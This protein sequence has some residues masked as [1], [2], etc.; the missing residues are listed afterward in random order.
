VWCRVA[1]S[2]VAMSLG[3][4]LRIRKSAPCRLFEN[5]WSLLPATRH[6]YALS[7]HHNWHVAT[8]LSRPK[9]RN[10]F[11]RTNA[12]SQG[13]RKSGM[14]SSGG[15]RSWK[16]EVAVADVKSSE[17]GRD[18]AWVE[19][20]KAQWRNRFLSV[21]TSNSSCDDRGH[22]ALQTPTDSPA[23]GNELKALDQD[24]PQA[25]VTPP[26]PSV[27][28]D[29]AAAAAAAAGKNICSG[30]IS[31]RSSYKTYMPCESLGSLSEVSSSLELDDSMTG[32]T[33]ASSYDDLMELFSS[34]PAPSCTLSWSGP[35]WVNHYICQNQRRLHLTSAN[36]ADLT[37]AMV[38]GGKGSTSQR[39]AHSGDFNNHS[40]HCDHI[41]VPFYRTSS[42]Q[43]LLA[44]ARP[45]YVRSQ[46]YQCRHSCNCSR[47]HSSQAWSQPAE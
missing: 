19:E 25:P 41:R 47:K 46:L 29:I 2:L 27:E 1:S 20:S 24:Q 16:D 4:E 45:S 3:R 18:K 22:D 21:N 10:H 17:R 43:R 12:E 37:R 42:S 8:N 15:A 14:P 38:A 33:I 44:Y 11:P 5:Q 34:T 36:S 7:G 13:T 31:Y 26:G 32:S 40:V 30:S 28:V 6:R 23:G 35:A 39:P 9:T